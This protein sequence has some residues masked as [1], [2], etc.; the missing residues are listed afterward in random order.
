MGGFTWGAVKIVLPVPG[1]IKHSMRTAQ[2]CCLVSRLG[3]NVFATASPGTA[4]A[5]RATE[6]LPTPSD[7]PEAS[8]FVTF[9]KPFNSRILR[10]LLPLPPFVQTRLSSMQSNRSLAAKTRTRARSAFG[11]R[12]CQALVNSTQVLVSR[13]GWYW[14]RRLDR[15][16]RDRSR[17]A[18]FS[19]SPLLSALNSLSMRTPSLRLVQSSHIDSS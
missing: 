13:Y 16:S 5:G 9:K 11:N 8:S 15:T 2:T 12:V 19:S 18:G 14:L 6:L 10:C 4:P 17:K 1:C 7:A 3:T